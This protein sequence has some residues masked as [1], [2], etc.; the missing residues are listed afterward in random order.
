MLKEIRRS[1]PGEDLLYLGDTARV[2]Y[3]SR[4]PATVERYSLNM[5]RFLVERGVKM[6]VV[7]CN[8]ASAVA[9][10]A[11]RETY[12]LPVIGVIRPG[13]EQAVAASRNHRIGVI[14]TRATILS[15]AYE[16]AIR[17]LNG[18]AH[19]VV[20]PCPLF[21]PLAEEGWVDDAVTR[22]VAERYLSPLTE[23]DIDTLVLGCTHYPILKKVI[24]SVLSPDMSIVDSAEA[25]AAAVKQILAS[26]GLLKSM[27]ELPGELEIFVTDAPEG[28]V[29]V[30]SRFFSEP[31]AQVRYID[32]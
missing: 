4:S 22:L 1:L 20:K 15:G 2:P 32:L 3:G 21:V 8:T 11:L 30:A 18:S 12:E 26:S 14:G 5:A 27:G 24:A 19:V 31:I 9:L 6:L 25:T 28:T 7:A 10:T 16:R 17:A 23:L 29:R 13:A